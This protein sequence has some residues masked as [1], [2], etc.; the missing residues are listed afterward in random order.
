MQ[1]DI[2][3]LE[4][5]YRNHAEAPQGQVND[6]CDAGQDG[7]AILSNRSAFTIEVSLGRTPI[8]YPSSCKSRSSR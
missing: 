7:K 2:T 1:S 3:S 8:C 4:M 6:R 5:A